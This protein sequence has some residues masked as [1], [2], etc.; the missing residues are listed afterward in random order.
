MYLAE[1]SPGLDA[2]CMVFPV[3]SMTAAELHQELEAL[4]SIAPCLPGA[5]DIRAMN[6]R[7]RRMEILY[8][9]SK[10]NNGLLTDLHMEASS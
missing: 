3:R 8:L 10:R 4:P 6:A 1:L 9:L 7:Q 2:D 5:Q